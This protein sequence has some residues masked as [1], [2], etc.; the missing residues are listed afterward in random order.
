MRAAA[1]HGLKRGVFCGG[2]SALTL[3]ALKPAFW[4]G[5]WVHEQ[6]LLITHGG[7]DIWLGI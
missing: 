5:A 6:M 7:G 4:A 1:L 3:L 2:L